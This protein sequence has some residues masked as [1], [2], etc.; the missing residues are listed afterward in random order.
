MKPDDPHNVKA[1]IE[2]PRPEKTDD[3]LHLNGMVNYLS[4][5]LPNLSDGMKPLSDLTLKNTEWCW[6]DTQEEA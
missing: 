2:M 1:I 6:S 3:V 5:F 4:H